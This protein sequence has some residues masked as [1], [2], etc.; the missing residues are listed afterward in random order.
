M[1]IPLRPAH[2]FPLYSW[3]KPSN[4]RE[5]FLELCGASPHYPWGTVQVYLSLADDVIYVT[6]GVILFV[7]GTRKP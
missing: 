1:G 7:L 2:Y 4:S 3:M 5:I 6:S